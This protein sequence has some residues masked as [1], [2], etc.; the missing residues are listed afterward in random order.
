MTRD[1][2]NFTCVST[3]TL[4]NIFPNI[5]HE[6]APLLPS[7]QKPESVKKMAAR[8]EKSGHGKRVSGR[9]RIGR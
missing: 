5:G 4:Q 8:S 3:A 9:A 7:A 6:K 1:I 2:A